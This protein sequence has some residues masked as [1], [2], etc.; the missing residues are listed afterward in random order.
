MRLAPAERGRSPEL[1]GGGD[2]MVLK[3]E[4][5]VPPLLYI[6]KNG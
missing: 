5:A 6:A 3:T 4:Q 1:M 2:R